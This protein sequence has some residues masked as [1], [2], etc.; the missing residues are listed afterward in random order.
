VK[1]VTLKVAFALI[2][3]ALGEIHCYD[4][5]RALQAC[6]PQRFRHLVQGLVTVAC[7]VGAK[8]SRDRGRRVSGG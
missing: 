3:V 6:L 5:V 7:R 1:G 4:E 2:Q 8:E